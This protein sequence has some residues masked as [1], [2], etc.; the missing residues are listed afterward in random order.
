M[1]KQ[2]AE[3]WFVQ[4][5]GMCNVTRPASGK[6]WYDMERISLMHPRTSVSAVLELYSS[7]LRLRTYNDQRL[8]R[9]SKE[10]NQKGLVW[11]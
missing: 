9:G 6:P 1:S 5:D 2:L 8:D 4:D 3:L 11:L 7:L 10:L